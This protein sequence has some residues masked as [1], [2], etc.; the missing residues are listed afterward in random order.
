MFKWFL[1]NHYHTLITHLISTWYLFSKLPDT[2]RKGWVSVNAAYNVSHKL[3][4]AM[5][6]NLKL[7]TLTWIKTRSEPNQSICSTKR[8][9]G[10]SVHFSELEAL[11]LTTRSKH[12]PKAISPHPDSSKGQLAEKRQLGSIWNPKLDR[13]MRY[14]N[15]AIVPHQIVW[16]PILRT[17]QAPNL[18]WSCS[19]VFWM[20]WYW[21]YHILGSALTRSVTC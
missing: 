11:F 15:E 19:W 1:Y 12:P 17:F 3:C 20:N 14:E 2:V 5:H 7:F 21:F 13:K 8:G 18:N 10:Y 6:K 9:Q 16:L 4:T